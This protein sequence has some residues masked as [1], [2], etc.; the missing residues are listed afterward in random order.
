MSRY[1]FKQG[2][3]RKFM[4]TVKIQIG[5]SW[6]E[7]AIKVGVSGRTLRDWQRETL[8][9]KKEVLSR[10]SNLSGIS[11]PPVIKEREEWWN[12]RAWSKKANNI[13]M[14]IYG[15]PGTPEGRSK[16]GKI[17]QLKRTLN[18][19]QYKGTGVVVRNSFNYPPESS[20]LAEFI[21]IM[22]GDGGVSKDQ[23]K[24]SLDMNADKEY[25]LVV[26]KL[27]QELFGKKPSLYN[28]K[29]FNVSTICLTG[30]N[31]VNYLI[32]RGLCI[33]SKMKA[34]VGIPKWIK[35]NSNYL[36]SCIRGL[37]DTDGCLFIHKYKYK[38]K[39]RE[40]GYKNICFVSAIPK[41]MADVKKQLQLLG[42]SPK[43]KG[44]KLFLYNQQEALRYLRE[45]GTSNPKNY[46]RWKLIKS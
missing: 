20:R 37:V 32:S 38:L 27:I 10:L 22:L 30:V 41:L 29:K 19:E 14:K 39:E 2:D 43:G 35:S 45:I 44:V 8:L 12:T 24:I 31:L 1:V 11:L 17:S 6:E 5:S 28:R 21:G 46:S 15:P 3:Q 25:V 18:P 9:G 23:I 36:K 7:I 40:Y 34:N 26:M 42:Y 4:R 13:R 16:G 33:G